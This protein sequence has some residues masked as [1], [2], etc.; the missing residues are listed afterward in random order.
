[1]NYR[2]KVGVTIEKNESIKPAKFYLLST[3]HVPIICKGLYAEIEL[4]NN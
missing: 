1:M 4:D 2:V 3:F